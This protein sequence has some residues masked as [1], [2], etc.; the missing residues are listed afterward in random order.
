MLD[1]LMDLDVSLASSLESLGQLPTYSR[2]RPRTGTDP[3]A[4]PRRAA[5]PELI[6]NLR[7]GGVNMKVV[8]LSGIDEHELNL[9]WSGVY[10]ANASRTGTRSSVLQEKIRKKNSL[11]SSTCSAMILAKE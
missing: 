3:W 2:Q 8:V 1:D 4:Y 11:H 9:A 5:V 10:T 7:T 6:R